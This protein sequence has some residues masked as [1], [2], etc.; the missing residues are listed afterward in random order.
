[1]TDLE[2]I[3]KQRHRLKFAAVHNESREL[4][5]YHIALGSAQVPPER[6][7]Y[8]RDRPMFL[9]VA[10]GLGIQGVVYKGLGRRG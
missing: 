6:V 4:T 9:E 7:V 1:M 10:Q 5:V 8:V 3:R 2:A